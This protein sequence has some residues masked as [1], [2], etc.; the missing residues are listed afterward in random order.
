MYRLSV[1]SSGTDGGRQLEL[2]QFLLANALVGR[3]LFPDESGAS[4]G[5]TNGGLWSAQLP[6]QAAPRKLARQLC[7]CFSS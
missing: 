1:K 3:S 6:A 4:A 7:K 5:P 2:M